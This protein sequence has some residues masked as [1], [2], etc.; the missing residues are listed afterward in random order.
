MQCSLS[1]TANSSPMQVLTSCLTGLGKAPRTVILAK[2]C[3]LHNPASPAA[4]PP[5]QE[6]PALGAPWHRTSLVRLLHPNWA[7]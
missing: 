7:Q 6:L 4:A 3:S 5:A 1:L 2:H